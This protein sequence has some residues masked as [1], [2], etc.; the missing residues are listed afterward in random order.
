M[1]L[2][3][4]AFGE[5]PDGKAVSIFTLTSQSGLRMR[6]T[7]YGGIIVSLHV[8]DRNAPAADVVL[9]Y[10]SLQEYIT[11]TPYFGAICGRVANRIAN[12]RFELDGTQ[13][14]LA[15]NNGDHSLH[16]GSIGFDKVV[17][18]AHQATG[19]NGPALRLEHTSPDGDEGYPGTLTV[20]ATYELTA[21]NGVRIL[22][23]ART[24]KPTPV[25]LTNHSY[26]NLAGAGAGDI[27]D[28][29]VQIEAD[30]YTP[31]DDT[32]IPTGER[33]SV[34]G[35]PLDF[36]NPTPIGARIDDVPGGY[37]HNYVL[38]G[39]AGELRRAATVVEPE[40]GRTMTVHTTEPGMQLY[41]GNFLDGSHI[42]K[43]GIPYK[44]HYG[45]CLET[46]HFPDS[47]NQPDFPSTILRPGEVY[48]QTTVYAFGAE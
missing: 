16:G 8:P 23:E 22:Y 31:V 15:A 2:S 3:Q 38:R 17:W 34:D 29:I 45:F 33:R 43:G 5:T 37:D 6:V 20:A 44:K 27:L 24:D 21:N 14:T 1:S 11:A 13:Y 26:F 32:L 4:T 25:N 46:Q 39:H 10:E 18:K 48:R 28:H 7:D 19:E 47:P 9:G 36:R 40:S 42:G 35:T 12:A 30:A 41:T